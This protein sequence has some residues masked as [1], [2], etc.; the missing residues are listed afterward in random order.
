MNEKVGKVGD[1]VTK[2]S[3]CLYVLALFV[4]SFLTAIQPVFAQEGAKEKETKK[5]PYLRKQLSHLKYHRNLKKR[6]LNRRKLKLQQL[7]RL[8]MVSWP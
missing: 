1:K 4:L 5:L 6:K 7:W 8:S 3:A 2:N